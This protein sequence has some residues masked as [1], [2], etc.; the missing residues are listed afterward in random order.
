MFYKISLSPLVKQC[1]IITY[2]HGIYKL[3]HKLPNDLRLRILGN[4]TMVNFEQLD[5][6][7][8]QCSRSLHFDSMFH[9]EDH[10]EPQIKVVPVSLAK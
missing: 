9:P 4:W 6:L 3:P 2:K 5:N 7:T 8:K 10:Q 1:L